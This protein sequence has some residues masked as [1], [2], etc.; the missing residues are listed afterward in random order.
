MAGWLNTDIYLNG[1]S[2]TYLDVTQRFPF[3]DNT[4]A[5]VTAEHMI[6][7]LAYEDAKTMLSECYW[8]LQPGGRVRIATPDLE[9]ILG[10]HAKE[11]TELQ[12]DILSGQEL[13]LHRMHRAARMF[14]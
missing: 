1:R 12:K 5:Y 4:F 3:Q 14:L 11:K 2:V 13:V 7:H 8:V 10:L 9:V 6:E